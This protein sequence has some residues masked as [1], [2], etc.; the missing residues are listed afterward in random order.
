MI[1]FVLSLDLKAP[2]NAIAKLSHVEKQHGFA[3][4]VIVKKGE[5]KK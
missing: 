2:V 1:F 4:K 3:G 5:K